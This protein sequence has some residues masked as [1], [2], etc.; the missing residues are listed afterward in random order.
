MEKIFLKPAAKEILLKNGGKDGASDTFAYDYDSDK[1]R[2]KLGNLYV[3]GNVSGGASAD[4]SGDDLD[5]GYVINLVASLAKREYYSNPELPVKDA[6]TSALKKINGVVEEFFKKKDTKINIGIFAIAGN[7]IHISKLGKFKI[8]LS[9]D[10]QNIDILNNLT[11]FNKEATQEKEFSSIISGQIHQGDKILAFYPSR[12]V[13][14]RERYLKDYLLKN[15]QE[16]FAAKLAVIKQEKEDFACAALHIDI[17]EGHE[18]AVEPHIQPRELRQEV[19]AAQLTA[20]SEETDEEPEEKEVEETTVPH[21]P[22]ASHPAAKSLQ[23]RVARAA[24][25]K[26]EI[27]KIIPSEFALGRKAKPFS[28]H[29]HRFKSINLNPRSKLVA[30]IGLAVILVVAFMSVKSLFFVSPTAKALNTAAAQAESNLKLAQSKI[31]QNDLVSA[32]SLLATTLVSITTAEAQ[33]GTSDRVNSAKDQVMEALDNLDGAVNATLS[34]I[35]SI[36]DGSGNASLLTAAGDDLYAYLSQDSQS[37]SLVKIA[38]GTVDQTYPFSDISPDQLLA[39]DTHVIALNLGQKKL[40]SL[41]VSDGKVSNSTLATPDNFTAA[42]LFSDNLYAID[43]SNIMKTADAALGK[44]DITPWLK[45]GTTLASDAS[46]IAVDGNA[47]VLTSGGTLDTYY[48]GK[49]TAEISTPLA[50]NNQE[51]LLSTEDGPNLYLVNIQL[52]RIYVLDKKAGTLVKTYKVNAQ[53]AIQSAAVTKDGTI[54]IL[55]ANK[56][57]KV[58]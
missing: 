47:Y 19:P 35:A 29:L 8:I 21:E 37:G 30:G 23:H 2:H 18:A 14:A 42:T 25:D 22:T 27:P 43:G 20:D 32:H 15:D 38:D 40:A 10:G 31:D 33:N 1:T 36:P 45:E 49:R 7:D 26:E 50:A 58:Q 12:T 54:Y 55:S 16:G 9:R 48:L 24:V 4:P 56:I 51:L 41:K 53:A 44:T 39:D 57:W 11:L 34:N 46:L 28:K 5:V 6:F 13:T 52:G 17:N 3:V